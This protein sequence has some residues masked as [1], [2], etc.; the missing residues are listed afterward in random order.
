M[1]PKRVAGK[2]LNDIRTFLAGGPAHWAVTKPIKLPA[3]L[4]VTNANGTLEDNAL[5]AYLSWVRN[6]DVGRFDR[7]HPKLAALFQHQT[8]TSAAQHLATQAPTS[9][10]SQPSHAALALVSTPPVTVSS[11]LTSATMGT[12]SSSSRSA[13]ESTPAPRVAEEVLAAPVPEPSALLT[14]LALFGL[15]VGWWIKSSRRTTEGG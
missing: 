9:T 13:S 15:A 5:V 8:A 1:F 14:A 3:H 11:L 7:Q 2:E 10:V 12:A 6:F 4:N